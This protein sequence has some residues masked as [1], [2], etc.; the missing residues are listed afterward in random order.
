VAFVRSQPLD[1]LFLSVVTF[2]EIRYGIE[3]LS[4][5]VRRAELT[6]WLTRRMRP[7]FEQRVLAVS[8]DVL[9]TWRLL[10]EQGRKVG[11]TFSQPD[12]FIAATARH[13]G[14]TVVSRDT[15][16]YLLAGASVFNPWKD[17]IPAWCR[18]G[19]DRAG[20]CRSRSRRIGCDRVPR[21]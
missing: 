14:L 11:H 1:A 18:C 13:H 6:D 9:V 8:E 7:M 19:C 10:V 16:E 12:L 4:D 21:L 17:K 20:L 2:A 3:L 5:A 15:A